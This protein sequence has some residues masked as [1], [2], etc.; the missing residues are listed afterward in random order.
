MSSV[1]PR[2]LV[3]G[4]GAQIGDFFE[5]RML[6]RPGMTGL[7]QVSGRSDATAAER[8]RLDFYYVENWSVLGDLHILARTVSAVLAR[9]G[10]C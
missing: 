8:V 3:S 2:P 5:R 4:K 10:A 6:V 1:G 7:W 9:S